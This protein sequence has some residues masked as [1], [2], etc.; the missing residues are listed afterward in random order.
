MPPFKRA[1]LS[2]NFRAG[3]AEELTAQL[4]AKEK[5]DEQL[6]SELRMNSKT[7]QQCNFQLQR[8]L[9]G[10]QETVHEMFLE[11]EQE[12]HEVQKKSEAEDARHAAED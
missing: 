4:R 11:K 5:I 3:A 12:I 10:M 2:S 6:M 7:A 8:T 9:S 1:R